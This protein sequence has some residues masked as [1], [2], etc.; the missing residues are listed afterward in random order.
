MKSVTNW[1]HI[2][3]WNVTFHLSWADLLAVYYFLLGSHVLTYSSIISLLNIIQ[4]TSSN[5]IEKLAVENGGSGTWQKRNSS[6][7]ELVEKFAK[8][9]F[10]QVQFD[11]STC[12]V[13]PTPY[14]ICTSFVYFYCQSILFIMKLLITFINFCSMIQFIQAKIYLDGWQS[15]SAKNLSYIGH[16][17]ESI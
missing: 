1:Q 17:K 14:N 5:S 8:F 15:K 2:T 10:R 16:I 11:N 9:Y 7:T 3:V 6:E 4:L 13:H 12:Q